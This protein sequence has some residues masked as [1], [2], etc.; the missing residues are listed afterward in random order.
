M[1]ATVRRVYEGM[2]STANQ[3]TICNFLLMARLIVTKFLVI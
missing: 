1:R 3:R 2:K